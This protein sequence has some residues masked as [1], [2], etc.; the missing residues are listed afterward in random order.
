MRKLGILTNSLRHFGDSLLTGVHQLTIIS[1]SPDRDGPNWKLCF[2]FYF[3][4]SRNNKYISSMTEVYFQ[5]NTKLL[6]IIIDLSLICLLIFNPG[7]CCLHI[8]FSHYWVTALH[9]FTYGQ[10][11]LCYCLALWHRGLSDRISPPRSL[12]V[13]W[14]SLLMWKSSKTWC[15][16]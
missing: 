1:H 3:R 14:K 11:W 12:V 6:F 9:S 15:F 8:H 7:T 5:L 2:L 16:L 4:K 13:W 10:F